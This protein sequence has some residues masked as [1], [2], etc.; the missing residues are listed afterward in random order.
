MRVCDLKFACRVVLGFEWWF[1]WIIY[2]PFLT[3]LIIFLSLTYILRTRTQREALRIEQ[4]QTNIYEKAWEQETASSQ[5]DGQVGDEPVS[6]EFQPSILKRRMSRR[7]STTIS[8]RLDTSANVQQG[9][10]DIM[11][12]H[13][14]ETCHALND[15]I[16]KK[17]DSEMRS[18][19]KRCP[20]YQILSYKIGAGGLGLYSMKGKRR[21]RSE[22]LGMDNNPVLQSLPAFT[23]LH[24]YFHICIQYICILV[25]SI[26]CLLLLAIYHNLLLV[27]AQMFF[28]KKPAY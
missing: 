6:T 18:Y 10:S 9:C 7:N 2:A 21:Q 13:I 28:L 19:F 25:S 27:F 24:L 8:S 11:L 12:Q 23:S 3:A 26:A 4:Y 1:Q 15:R 20:W 14:D 5:T 22:N 17:R 16:S